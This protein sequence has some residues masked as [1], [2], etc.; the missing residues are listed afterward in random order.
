MT[1]SLTFRNYLSLDLHCFSFN[2]FSTQF[3]FSNRHSAAN[4]YQQKS[5]YTLDPVYDPDLWCGEEHLQPVLN[6]LMNC[7]HWEKFLA[8]H[9]IWHSVM[10]QV[11]AYV[12]F[13]SKPHKPAHGMGYGTIQ[14]HSIIM[15]A[16]F[17]ADQRRND[18]ACFT[19]A[20]REF[21]NTGSYSCDD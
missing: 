8:T 14:I 2:S 13:S 10:V 11:Y 4:E 21:T 9:L 6:F 17:S 16:M 1:N 7:A 5:F 15:T 12:F 3:G 20:A 19:V 18:V